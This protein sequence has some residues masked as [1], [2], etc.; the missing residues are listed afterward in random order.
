MRMNQLPAD[1]RPYEKCLHLGE[2]VLSDAELI[3]VILR[4]GS[5]RESALETAR[6]I[7]DQPGCQGLTGLYH[8]SVQDLTRI[9]GI[10]PVK[11]VQLRCICELSRRIHKQHSS[12][13][14]CFN[15]PQSVADYYME[16][17]RHAGQELVLLLMLDTKGHL[18]GEQVIS[19][20]SVDCALIA[21]REVF[22]RA[23]SFR[24]VSVILIHNHP[25][26]DPFPSEEDIHL[27][28]NIRL[29]GELLG[30]HLLDHIIVGDHTS[31]SF[32]RE[33]LL[34]ER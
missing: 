21:P 11:A 4:T 16:D 22:L 5:R 20:G 14:L 24:A 12:A 29:G 10:G 23:F 34:T 8:M 15:D 32:R 27:T 17:L 6:R 33:H 18:L 9:D 28:E 2:Q 30:I 25:S 31:F 3:S 13:A 7:L 19:I 26:G 1:E